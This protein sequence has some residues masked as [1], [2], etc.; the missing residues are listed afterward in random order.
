[1]ITGISD[2]LAGVS[3]TVTLLI[4]LV[5]VLAVVI[6]L[7]VFL[8]IS[9]ERAGEFAVL[10][11]L[12]ASRQGLGRMVLTESALCGVLG[13]AAGTA[14]AALCIFP[15]SALIEQQLSLP[16]LLPGAGTILALA[17]GTVLLASA[18][19]AAAGFLAARRLSRVDPGSALRG[20]T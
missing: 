16:Y 18:V 8:M 20:G 2:S 9:R 1:M 19:S 5:W 10:R 13:G 11:L 14:L 7:L 6:L 15:F 17:L 12:G 4:A 3:R